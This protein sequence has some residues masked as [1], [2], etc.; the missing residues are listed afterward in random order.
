MRRGSWLCGPL[1][2][3]AVGRAA[4][5]VPCAE[6][7]SAAPLLGGA[8]IQPPDTFLTWIREAGEYLGRSVALLNFE[9]GDITAAAA[10]RG[11]WYDA[12]WQFLCGMYLGRP[13][14]TFVDLGAHIGLFA[15]PMALCLRRV[16]GPLG[17]GQVVAVEAAPSYFEV[18]RANL[19]L[20]A[21]L[22]VLAFPFALDS[23]PSGYLDMQRGFGGAFKAQLN[24]SDDD[25]GPASRSFPRT[26]LDLMYEAYPHQMR[27]VLA[28]KMDMEGF[29]GRAL[30]GATRFLAEAP[31][32][33]LFM[34]AIP[35]MLRGAGT[36]I[37]MVFDLLELMGY[38]VGTAKQEVGLIS[39]V[40]LPQAD[41]EG[42]VALRLRGATHH[43]ADARRQAA[44]ALRRR[45]MSPGRREDVAATCANV[46][47]KAATSRG[48]RS[49]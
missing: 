13:N 9:H 20:N 31:P 36:P 5:E 3:A 30:L 49:N 29:E 7:P 48:V 24:V 14:L 27:R 25:L 26:T 46:T 47:T 22:D 34:E 8:V 11:A 32:C 12:K 16:N 15:V 23:H 33:Y 41:L 45:A 17:A 40:V 6:L 18:L 35:S 42:C 37:R 44:H 4:A 28:M 19:N 1:V 10:R 2:A 43:K 38:L 21:A 39:N